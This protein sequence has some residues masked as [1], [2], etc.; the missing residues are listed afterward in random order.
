MYKPELIDFDL[1]GRGELT[2]LVFIAGVST[3]PTCD[4]CFDAW[5][6]LKGHSESIPVMMIRLHALYQTRQ[7]DA[8][9][10]LRPRREL[11]NLEGFDT[12][13]NRIADELG[14]QDYVTG[15]M[16]KN[17]SPF[18]LAVNMASFR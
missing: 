1:T 12:H 10:N 15:E 3:S 7:C 2:R 8:C 9:A 4:T 11:W 14:K 5:P 16:W 13:R 18:L 6:A 17:I